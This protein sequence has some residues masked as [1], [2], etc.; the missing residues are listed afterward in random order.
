MNL[1]RVVLMCAIVGMS[2]Y[3]DAAPPDGAT[4]QAAEAR[5]ILDGW[6]GN[7]PQPA[8]RLLHIIVWRPRDREFPPEQAD[9][10]DRILTSIQSFYRSEMERHG[11]GPRTIQLD[12]SQDGRIMIHEV[13]GADAW[14]SYSKADGRRIR[15][16][17]V[18]RLRDKGIDMDRETVMIFT[19]LAEWD[20]KKRSFRHKSPYYGSGDWQ[21]GTAWQLDSPELDTINLPRKAPLIDDGEYGRISLGKHNSIFLGGIAHELGHALGLPHCRAR[22]DEEQYG[23]A[24]MG[25]GNRTFGDEQRGEGKGSFITLAHALRL[26]SHPQFSGSMKGLTTTARGSFAGLSVRPTA[27]GKAFCITGRVIG[28]PPVYAVIGY[29]DPEG[30]GDYDARTISTVPDG[31]GNFSLTCSALVPGKSAD[32]RLV[33]CHANGATRMANHPFRVA[34][35]GTVDIE[36]MQTMFELEPFFDALAADGPEAARRVA[37]EAGPA[38]RLAEAILLGRSGRRAALV[39]AT[40]SDDTTRLLLSRARP[41]DATVGWLT[42]AYDCLPRREAVIEASGKLYESGIYAHAPGRHRYELGGKWAQMRGQCG[43]PTQL[44]GSVV[45]VIQVDGREVFRSNK[46][47]SGKTEHYDVDLHGVDELLLITEDGGDGKASDWGVW[48]APELSR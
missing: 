6:H 2:G 10:L 39:P 32:V 36:T 17:C 37:P 26:A 45:F 42:P 8:A 23:T 4:R 41:T 15:G 5:A 38:A 20:P 27:D 43:L 22:P 48:L 46:L 28:E 29:L 30:G 18:P 31:V 24:L 11:L 16:E 14:N 47:T 44:A 34:Q 12:R 35:D 1:G 7:D 9:R 13:V 21:H 25:S 40:V 19:N 33:A 3:G